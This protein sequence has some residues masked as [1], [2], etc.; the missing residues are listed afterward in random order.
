[1]AYAQAHT[2]TITTAADGTGTG[3]TPT[4]TGKILNVRYTKATSGGYDDGI[5]IDVETEATG[6]TIWSQDDV[7]ATALVAPRQATHSTAGV[8]SLYAAG[9][10]PVEDY[11]YACNERIKISVGSGGEVKTGTF[12]VIVGG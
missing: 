6:Q 3:Y 7:N 1:M 4:V 5:D 8:A 10:E 11:I 12:L 9:G 2:V